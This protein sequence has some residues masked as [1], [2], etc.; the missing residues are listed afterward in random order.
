MRVVLEGAGGVGW[1]LVWG[2][3]GVMLDRQEFESA[4]GRLYRSLDEINEHLLRLNGRTEETETRV[5]VLETRLV[6]IGG[7]LGTGWAVVQWLWK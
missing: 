7:V 5:T 4:M 3:S 6:T 1:W 2:V